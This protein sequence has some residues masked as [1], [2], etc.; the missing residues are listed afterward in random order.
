MAK[1][2]TR[3][4]IPMSKPREKQLKRQREKEEKFREQIRTGKAR[5]ERNDGQKKK[6]A[7]AN[8]LD[9]AK[10]ADEELE[11]RQDTAER[12]T[13]VY[14]Q[15]LPS[16]LN[17]LSRIKNPRN[18][19]KVKH[20]KTV[21][22]LYG[23]LMFVYQIGSRR[24]ANRTMDR[25]LFENLQ[26]MFP[27]LETMPH[28]DTLARLLKVIDVSEIQECMVELIK[29]LIKR[30][31]F[32]NYLYK[33]SYIIAI[34]GTQK[35]CRNWQWDEKCLE[36]TVGS[37]NKTKQYYVYVLE[38]VLVLDNGITLPLFSMFLDN[39]DWKKGE[40]KQDC[41]TKAFYRMA[42]KLKKLFRNTRITLSVDG[43]YATGPVIQI[44]RDNNWGY[45]IVLKEDCLPT[46]WDDA[47]GLMRVALENSFTARWGNRSQLYTW[48]N[49]I[50]YEYKVGK[51]FRKLKLNVVLCYETWQEN[52]SQSTGKIEQKET[53]YA[54][55]S[56]M[57][58][59]K[60]NVFDRCIKV[61][62]YRWKIEN[63]ILAEKHQGYEY[64]HCYS[65]SWNAMEGYHYLMKIGRLLNVLA[66]NSE[67]LADKIISLGIQGFI[68]YLKKVCSGSLLNADRIREAANERRQ[69][70]LT[71]IA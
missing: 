23:M 9:M 12:T 71:L 18:P 47:L 70:R 6:P 29:D 49:D 39:G 40:T 55:I 22:L 53:R 69:W 57:P 30:K 37:E 24:E 58:L 67:L 15:M 64:E 19:N 45:M 5:Y 32:R 21:L 48:A 52:H 68:A 10:S 54:W 56:H 63:N 38:S 62:R 44:C 41:E 3:Q 1:Y 36:R 34:D 50:E 33:K 7:I 43:L 20:K 35:M 14:R 66:A 27:E 8:R 59:S 31:K 4:W 11:N 26:A 51:G 16:L 28:A 13:I 65:Y 42:K 2:R 25:I 46:V 60:K 17:K 61:G